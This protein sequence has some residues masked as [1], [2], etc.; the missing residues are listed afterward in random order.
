MVQ[1]KQGAENGV[2]SWGGPGGSTAQTRG[3][4]GA[5]GG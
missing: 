1:R 2:G 4:S 3:L 5:G